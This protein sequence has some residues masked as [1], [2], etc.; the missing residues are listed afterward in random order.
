[1]VAGQLAP[2]ITV[3]RAE[4]ARRKAGIQITR[5]AWK[6]LVFTGGPGTGKSR[7]A[8]AL[9]RLYQDLGLLHYGNL[10]EIPAADLAGT[11]PRDTAA[12]IR[13]AIKV[14]GNLVMIT[15]AHV[16]HD[17]PARP[18]PAHPPLPVPAPHRI[19]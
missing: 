4:Q 10:I 17:L 9:A 6:N 8:T 1:M 7:A 13:E 3:L 18:R 12:Q 14:T 16:W 5:P 11:T 2:L 19:P 15:G